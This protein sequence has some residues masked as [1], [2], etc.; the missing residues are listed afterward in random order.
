MAVEHITTNDF[1]AKVI[2]AKGVV[3]VDFYAEWCGPC[4]MLAPLVEEIAG[5]N[6]DVTVYKV[7]VDEENALAVRFRVMS[8]PTLIVFKDGV[9]TKTSMGFISKQELAEL[10]RC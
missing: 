8:I 4:K 1:E 5:E 6:P 9:Q 3:L 7:N 2:Q 10:I